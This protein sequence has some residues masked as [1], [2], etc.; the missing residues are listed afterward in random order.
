MADQR[1]T[2]LT[3]ITS[4]ADGDVLYIVD[5]SDTTDNAAGSSK[6]ITLSNFIANHE[7]VGTQLK[8]YSLTANALGNVSG[9]TTIDLSLGNYVTA[10][11]TA[12]TT[13]TFS[14]APSTSIAGGFILVLT[15]G[16]AFTQNWPSPNVKW[17]G[18][19]A[20]TLTASGTDVLMF[21]TNDAGTTWRGVVSMLDSK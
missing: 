20:P 5:V 14:N 6:K 3:A 8:Q 12:L 7:Y 21:V 18:G 10:T 17:P 4:A 16:G 2:S 19:V 11:S 9:A 1:V 15:N 13:W